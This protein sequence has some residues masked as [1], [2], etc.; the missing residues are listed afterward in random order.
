MNYYYHH[1]YYHYYY[2][3]HYHYLL[4]YI[5]YVGGTYLGGSGLQSPTEPAICVCVCRNAAFLH[6]HVY[7]YR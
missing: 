1:H 5:P 6:R 2:Y 7:M 4:L 3:Y